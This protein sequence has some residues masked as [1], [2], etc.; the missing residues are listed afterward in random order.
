ML[1]IIPVLDVKQGRVV[2]AIAGQRQA[3]QPI[4]SGLTSSTD[5]VEM[6]RVLRDR[7]EAKE[8][9]VAD[10]DAI[11]ARTPPSQTVVRLIESQPGRI[12]LDAG[13]SQLP[14]PENQGQPIRY[15]PILSLERLGLT[16]DGL[17]DTASMT[18]PP[19]AGIADDHPGPSSGQ[20]RPIFSLD[21]YGES[22]W[23]NGQP[24]GLFSEM[25]LQRL[26]DQIDLAGFRTLI[27][28]DLQRVGTRSGPGSVPICRWIARHWPR[29]ELIAGG[30]IRDRDDLNRLNDAGVAGVLVATAL[31]EGRLP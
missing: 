28:L 30:G 19:V 3:Y 20:C 11:L 7:T 10:L 17:P 6:A 2:Q 1:R 31:H 13:F 27:V 16:W 5:P 25:S 18:L 14:K 26:L 9:Y 21:L 23:I 12:W 8:L 24:A 22:F 15:R 4:R 29:L